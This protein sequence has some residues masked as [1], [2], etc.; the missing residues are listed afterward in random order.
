MTTA[1]STSKTPFAFNQTIRPGLLVGIKTSV[2]GNV[3]Y[4]KTPTE[5]EHLKDGGEKATWDTERHIKDVAEQEEATKI[6]GQARSLISSICS[7][8]N[9]GYLCPL[10]AK[11]ELMTKIDEAQ[12]LCDEFNARSRVTKVRF[13]AVTGT[14]QQDDFQA[15]RMLRREVTELL[16]DMKEGL[17]NLDVATVREAANR[18]KQLGQ[19]LS[20]EAEVRLEMAIKKVRSTARKIAA[21]GEQGEAEIDRSTIRALTETRTMFLDLD[22]VKEVETPLNTGRAVDL[23]EDRKTASAAPVAS[24][25]MDLV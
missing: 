7:T 22:D 6:R 23:T 16:T 18:A 14:I 17:E 13:G 21:A 15:V 2:K 5:V 3:T 1:L 4:T 8:T 12:K 19:M 11:P 25:Q 24:R 10:V 20:P 9:F